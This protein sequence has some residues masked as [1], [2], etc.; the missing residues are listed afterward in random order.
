MD[1]DLS[2]EQSLVADNL[3]RLLKE[4]YGFDQRKAYRPIKK[5]SVE[6][7][8]IEMARQPCGESAFAEAAGPSI[9]ISIGN[10]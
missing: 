7:W 2:E 9:A 4:K 1:F 3:G 10:P 6:V 8:D 5:P